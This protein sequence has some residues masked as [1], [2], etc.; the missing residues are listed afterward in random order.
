MPSPAIV[1]AVHPSW[2]TVT[3][4]SA[5]TPMESLT[6]ARTWAGMLRSSGTTGGPA[7]RTTLC[8]RDR[9]AMAGSLDDTSL[10][11][12]GFVCAPTVLRVSAPGGSCCSCTPLAGSSAA[13]PAKRKALRYAVGADV[14]V[15][16]VDDRHAPEHPYPAAPEDACAGSFWSVEH[17]DEFREDPARI[18][19]P[20]GSAGGNPVLQP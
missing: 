1:C 4:S 10:R 17:A 16:S 12:A 11:T 7:L 20:G 8:G 19:V 3:S 14:G 18:A 2:V 13:R 9:A 5:F 6:V 15:V